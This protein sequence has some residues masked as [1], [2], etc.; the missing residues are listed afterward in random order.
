MESI[1]SG[2]IRASTGASEPTQ[3]L[4]LSIVPELRRLKG[5]TVGV[6]NQLQ[7]EEEGE[8]SLQEF[9]GQLDEIS[10][11]VEEPLGTWMKEM[12]KALLFLGDVM[13]MPPPALPKP[14]QGIRIAASPI[15]APTAPTIGYD[16]PAEEDQEMLED[17]TA[18]QEPS[19]LDSKGWI[20]DQKSTLQLRFFT[21]GTRESPIE[22][23]DSPIIKCEPDMEVEEVLRLEDGEVDETGL[24]ASIPI[25]HKTPIRSIEDGV[26][27]KKQPQDLESPEPFEPIHLRGGNTI[28][29]PTQCERC[30][31]HFPS[32]KRMLA[33][34]GRKHDGHP[35]PL[36]KKMQLSRGQTGAER[37]SPVE[38]QPE[39]PERGR[40]RTW[41]GAER[42]QQGKRGPRGSRRR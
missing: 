32:R 20:S 10:S 16:V 7:I 3:A 13:A 31:E 17:P 15:K 6:L 29:K 41:S 18:A 34:F 40:K 2:L 12:G 19:A 4:L 42:D 36:W 25:R 5:A 38:K 28:G 14:R 21:S 30:N 1:I 11:V 39:Q 23:P 24:K 33:H 9:V 27:I 8:V 35:Q 22:L 37:L 26:S